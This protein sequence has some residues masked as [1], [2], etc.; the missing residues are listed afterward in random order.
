MIYKKNLTQA[1]QVFHPAKKPLKTWWCIVSDQSDL[2]VVSEKIADSSLVMNYWTVDDDH[3]E[4]PH[5]WL[6]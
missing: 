4:D 3:E 2:T 6:T 5:Q 1:D